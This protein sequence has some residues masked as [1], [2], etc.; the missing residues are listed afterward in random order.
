MATLD[1][2]EINNETWTDVSGQMVIGTAY[3][4]SPG[5][6]PDFILV[7]KATTPVDTDSRF[8]LRDNELQEVTYDG[9]PFWC[10]SLAPSSQVQIQEAP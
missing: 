8:T 9:D 2:V 4:V 5:G 7:E 3:N 6:A 1:F 10:K